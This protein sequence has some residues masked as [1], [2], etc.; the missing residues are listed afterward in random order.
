MAARRAGLFPLMLMDGG[1]CVCVVLGDMRLNGESLVGSST[2]SNTSCPFL[3]RCQLMLSR[4]APRA[5]QIMTNP[6][7]N[8]SGPG[9][10]AEAGHRGQ[11]WLR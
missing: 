1:V 3:A 10:R 5:L 7:S 2:T 8:T 9:G 11:L 6:P 4:A